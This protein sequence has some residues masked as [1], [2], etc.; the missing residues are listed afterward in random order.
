MSRVAKIISII[1]HPVFMPLAGMFVI[2]NSGIFEANIPLEHKNYMYFFVGIFSVILPLSFFPLLYYWRI[3]KT[4]E[5]TQKRERFLPLLFTTIS[6]I[7]L[8]VML[9]RAVSVK[10]FN[11]Y[12]FTLAIVS[13]SVLLIN[14]FFKISLH[15]TALGGITGLIIVLSFLYNADLFYWLLAIVFISGIIGSARLYNGSHSVPEVILGY[16]LGLSSTFGLMFFV[17]R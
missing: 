13:L 9:K 15:L 6:L 11:A 14:T 16:M 1:L 2:L 3:I 17:I 10:L 4:S 5:L 12:T 7:I 8:H